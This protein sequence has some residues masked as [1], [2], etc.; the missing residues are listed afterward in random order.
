M[1][2]QAIHTVHITH[3]EKRPPTPAQERALEEIVWRCRTLEN[4]ASPQRI[5]AW[6]RRHISSS[7]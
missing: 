5:T 3:K 6:R 1:D 7:R 2:Q 4:T